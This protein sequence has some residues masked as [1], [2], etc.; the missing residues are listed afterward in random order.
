M[1]IDKGPDAAQVVAEVERLLSIY[2]ENRSFKGYA[3]NFLT[4]ARLA[5]GMPIDPPPL[6][7]ER[8]NQLEIAPAVR[9]Y[10]GAQ[11]TKAAVLMAT[12]ALLWALS[13]PDADLRTPG[14]RCF[15]EL[16]KLWN[17]RFAE[18]YPDGLRVVLPSQ[19]LKFQYR[20]ASGAF[21]IDVPGAHAEYPDI[22]ALRKAPGDLKALLQACEEELELYSRFIGRNPAKRASLEAALLLPTVLQSSTESLAFDLAG[23]NL[24][25]IM[26]E[27]NTATTKLQNILDAFGL[28]APRNGKFP[29]AVCDRLGQTLD[30]LNVAIE[31]DRRYGN[32]SPQPGDQVVLFR[33]DKGGPIDASKPAYQAMK[34][35][36]EVSALA[37]SADGSATVDELQAII[38]NIK[39]APDLTKVEGLRLIAY[40]IT[41][42]KSPPKQKRI[43]RQLTQLSEPERRSIATA[44]KAV[45]VK[46]FGVSADEV[47]FFE[48]L[49]KALGLPKDEVYSD[50]HRAAAAD[51]PVLVSS[52]SRV[53]G[54]PIPPESKSSIKIDPGRLAAVQMQTQQVSNLLSQVFVDETAET[55]A[56][57]REWLRFIIPQ[58]PR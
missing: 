4:H 51:E 1:F 35:Q 19:R 9:V 43:L 12:D 56:R 57:S 15:D 42:F 58:R 39:A 38:A 17:V 8:I 28:E 5:T 40:S 44:A 26:G 41:I 7:P 53:P 13:L 33:S 31:P 11:L 16:V 29:Q 20:A 36:V 49:H 22:A 48:R 6:S 23:K 34:A 32:G 50:L 2:G 47:R 45:I 21:E 14:V 52:E 24:D 27:R 37:A 54:V 3:S 10:L 18:R 25:V 55:S 30:C 46:P